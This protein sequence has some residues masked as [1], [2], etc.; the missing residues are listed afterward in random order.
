MICSDWDWKK[1]PNG[2]DKYLTTF[3]VKDVTKIDVYSGMYK[4]QTFVVCI[5]FY[6][7]DSIIGA[8]YSGYLCKNNISTIK[9]KFI[10][11]YP[12]NGYTC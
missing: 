1:N 8:P 11:N 2:F 10:D 3:S 6:N 4:S 7:G 5:V 9:A 12:N